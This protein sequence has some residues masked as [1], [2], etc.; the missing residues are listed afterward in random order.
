MC[1]CV[2]VSDLSKAFDRP[3]GP[4]RDSSSEAVKCRY[5]RL[6]VGYNWMV[7]YFSGR[8]HCAAF[9]GQI[10][11]LLYIPASIIQGYQ[12]LDQCHNHTSST[13]VISV[14]LL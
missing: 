9:Y 6:Y 4:S 3:Y 7:D 2:C 11:F 12:L 1:V 13:Q 8:S 14:S 10:S 5:S